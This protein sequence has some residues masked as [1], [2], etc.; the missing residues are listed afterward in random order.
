MRRGVPNVGGGLRSGT[1]RLVTRLICGLS[2]AGWTVRSTRLW[3]LSHLAFQGVVTRVR[4]F[5]ALAGHRSSH[6]GA[7]K[8]SR[9]PG[10]TTVLCELMT[11]PGY[12]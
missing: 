1:D 4:P 7:S 2:G 9:R 8:G 12:N 5:P 3:A 10:P 11:Q 6:P